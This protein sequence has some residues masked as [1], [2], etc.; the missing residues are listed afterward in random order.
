[1]STSKAVTE[2][3]DGQSAS[4][5]APARAKR[6]RQRKSRA[7]DWS[8]RPLH[9][10]MYTKEEIAEIEKLLAALGERAKKRRKIHVVIFREVR[11]RNVENYVA[12]IQGKL[13]KDTGFEPPHISMA[14]YF[15]HLLGRPDPTRPFVFPVPVEILNLDGRE[16]FPPVQ[17]IP[18]G[19][20][21]ARMQGS[22]RRGRSEAIYQYR[23]SI[24]LPPRTKLG[25]RNPALASDPRTIRRWAREDSK[26]H[27]TPLPPTRKRGRKFI[28]NP[29]KSA[30]FQRRYRERKRR[31]LP[32]LPRGAKPRPDPSPKLVRDQLRRAM[33]KAEQALQEREQRQSAIPD[34]MPIS[35][36]D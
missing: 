11:D 3:A 1:M 28:A 21:R 26:R 22:T 14:H 29:T 10:R 13:I 8:Y 27:G 4:V 20:N 15:S 5:E 17:W 7:R 24:G 31:R 25:V 32:A 33:M 19:D 18:G 36:T 6:R 34:L 2:P 12:G 16:V 30:L 9:R 35:A 23:C